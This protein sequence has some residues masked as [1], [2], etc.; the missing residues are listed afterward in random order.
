MSRPEQAH[1][2]ANA[3]FSRQPDLVLLWIDAGRLAEELRYERVTDDG[4]A[5]VFPHLYRRLDLAAVVD[6]VPLAAWGPGSFTLPR[7]PE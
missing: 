3:I 4:E 6:V 5:H 7:A 2:P 1:L